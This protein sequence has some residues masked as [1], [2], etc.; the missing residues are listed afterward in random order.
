MGPNSSDYP[1]AAKPRVLL[2]SGYDAGSHRRW[3][4]QLVASQPDFDWQVLTLP[5]RFFRW[6]I[7]GNPLTWLR[8]PAL[9]QPLDL[10]LVT[11][12]VDLATLRGVHPQLASTPALL[13][14]HEN[15]FAYPDSG[16][17]HASADPLMVNLYSAL[18]ATQVAFNSAWNRDSFLEGVSRF[19]ARLP[20]GL[21]PGLIDELRHK[22][23]I[24]PVPIEDR[25]FRARSR[26]FNP[27]CPHLLWN[28]RWEYDK[29]PEL[30]LRLL[31]ELAIRGQDF[32]LSVVGEQFR[33]QPEAFADIRH[34][35][36][37][38]IVNWG[39]L[40]T[41]S[42]YDRL[43]A[44]ADFVLSTALHDFQGL[45]MLEAMASGCIALAPARLAYPEYIPADQLYASLPD[46]PAAEA[47][48]AV[49]VLL[50]LLQAEPPPAVP[51][52]WRLTVL[53]AKYHHVMSVTLAD[54][55]VSSPVNE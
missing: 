28:H 37:A 4:E 11:S 23:V 26:P 9:Q 49:D 30:L 3:R 50:A 36:A 24:L 27:T 38:R 41:R 52:E 21:P 10:L 43:L 5:P 22:S 31:D 39:F 29:G 2:L 18:A 40:E 45:S 32:Q 48:S 6:R 54:D 33:H 15:Q 34:R 8:E 35:H 19:L 46:D 25:L 7:R 53:K 44:E 47:H 14:M 20:D 13:Y 12:M 1:C 55:A 42:D 51:D 17:Q 16:Q